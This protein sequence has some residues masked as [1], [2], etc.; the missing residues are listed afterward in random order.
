MQ[1]LIGF[2][3]HVI[4]LKKKYYGFYLVNKIGFGAL[5]RFCIGVIDN[6]VLKIDHKFKRWKDDVT[7]IIDFNSKNLFGLL[8]G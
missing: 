7:H 3:D 4:I 6:N 5:H 2:I 1:D 8:K